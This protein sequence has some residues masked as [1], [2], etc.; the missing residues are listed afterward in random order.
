MTDDNEPTTL[1]AAVEMMTYDDKGK[2]TTPL[3]VRLRVWRAKGVRG[4][5]RASFDIVHHRQH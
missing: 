5:A 3:A 1:E 2:V 4:Y